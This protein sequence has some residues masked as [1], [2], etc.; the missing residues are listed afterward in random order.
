[1][2]AKFYCRSI[3]ITIKQLTKG[4]NEYLLFYI[5]QEVLSTAGVYFTT[6]THIILDKLSISGYAHLIK[7]LCLPKYVEILLV[8]IA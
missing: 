7:V 4:H 2:S 1:M 5:T 6:W 3:S 8:C